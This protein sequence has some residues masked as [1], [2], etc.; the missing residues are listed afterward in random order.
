MNRMENSGPSILGNNKMETDLIKAKQ[1][2]MIITIQETNK[3][4]VKF[5]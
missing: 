3:N 1:F 2:N 5:R 4:L